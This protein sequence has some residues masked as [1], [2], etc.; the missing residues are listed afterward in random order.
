MFSKRLM[1]YTSSC[2]YYLFL[3]ST[4]SYYFLRANSICLLCSCSLISFSAV[5]FFL[6]FSIFRLISSFC[7]TFTFSSFSS[8]YLIFISFSSSS[9]RLALSCCFFCVFCCTIDSMNLISLCFILSI[10]SCRF[11]S[12]SSN[13][14]ATFY[15]WTFLRL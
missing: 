3:F 7:S 15:F 10:S 9:F 1:L 2:Y 4:I 13:I 11:R 5:N 6:I 8:I 12:S 14:L